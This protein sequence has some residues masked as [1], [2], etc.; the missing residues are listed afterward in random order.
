MRRWFVL[1]TVA[2]V[3][4]V[5]L[6]VAPSAGAQ[7]TQLPVGEAQGVRIERARGAIVVVFGQRADRLWRRMAERFRA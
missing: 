4:T 1:A 5:L 2:T 6:V 7:T 3:A